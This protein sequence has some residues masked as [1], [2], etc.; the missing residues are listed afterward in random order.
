MSIYILWLSK[1]T[2]N[3]K[4]PLQKY[5]QFSLQ[6]LIKQICNNE[7]AK[8]DGF[9]KALLS[10][11]FMQF[12][13]FVFFRS[14][15]FLNFGWWKLVPIN[16][17]ITFYGIPHFHCGQHNLRNISSFN[18]FMGRSKKTYYGIVSNGWS[19]IWCRCNASDY[20]CFIHCNR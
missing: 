20:C 3:H 5:I 4:I 10:V 16:S 18:S 12:V 13:L 15:Y 9:L 6:I 8:K 7:R 17:C 1:K 2:I 11:A 19:E 14:F